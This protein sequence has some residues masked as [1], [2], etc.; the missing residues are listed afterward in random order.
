MDTIFNRTDAD[1]I[2]SLDAEARGIYAPETIDAGDVDD[3]ENIKRALNERLQLARKYDV[4]EYIDECA[5]LLEKLA[6]YRKHAR[7]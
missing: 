6:Y 5:R 2:A 1:V 3:A 7:G 4:P